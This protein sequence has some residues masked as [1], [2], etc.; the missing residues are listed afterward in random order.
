MPYVAL[1]VATR[2][3]RLAVAR[4]RWDAILQVR[5]DLLPAIALQRSLLEPVI[6]L[7]HT[8]G[9]GRLPRL[10]LPP[11]YVAAKLGKQIPALGGEPIPMPVT[12][13]RPT[14]LSLCQHLA[15]GGGGDPALQIHAVLDAGTLDPGAVLSATL[16]RDQKAIKIAALHRHLQSELVWL[17]AELAVSPY[18]YHLQQMVL[19]ERGGQLDPALR[20]AL[21][22]WRQGYCPVCGSWPAMIE[23]LAGR[24]ILRCSFCALAWTLDEPGCAYCGDIGPTFV[25]D[26]PDPA[27]PDRRVETCGRCRSYV[28][29]VDVDELS[30]FPLGAIGDLETMDLDMRVM[31]K[32][33]QRPATKV[34]SPSRPI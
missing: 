9:Q 15:E 4:A 28:K 32:G 11:R 20:S 16:I 8:L 22:H 29:A 2:E 25:T 19:G 27:R 21:D 17:V 14:L 13:I 5:P 26:V 34:F 7:T 18:V 12:L 31:K 3:S 24:S 10:S 1:P 6:E 33:F 23:A 30:P